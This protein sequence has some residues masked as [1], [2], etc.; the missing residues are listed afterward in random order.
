[1]ITI[2]SG[3]S[4]GCLTVL[5]LSSALIEGEEHIHLTINEQMTM[6]VIEHGTASVIIADDGGILKLNTLAVNLFP[7]SSL[8]GVTSICIC[9]SVI[10]NYYVL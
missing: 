1:M 9:R 8:A 10:D 6:A 2:H 3:M 5:V 7:I 4:W